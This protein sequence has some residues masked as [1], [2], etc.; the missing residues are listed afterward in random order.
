MNNK[1]A[2]QDRF[3][4]LLDKT[5]E[6]AIIK[7]ILTSPLGLANDLVVCLFE[8]RFKEIKDNLDSI[9]KFVAGIN[10]A[11]QL[12]N[13]YEVA[14][15]YC[16][17]FSFHQFFHSSYRARQGKTLE[18]FFKEIIRKMNASFVV[19]DKKDEK[20]ELMN[21][22]FNKYNSELDID[23]IAKKSNNRI[24]AIQLRSRDDTGGTTAKSSLVE[25]LRDALNLEV[26]KDA[27]LLYLVCVWD[28][29]KGNQKNATIKK[30]YSSLRPHLKIDESSF[31]KKIETGL[32]VKKG[33]VLKMSYGTDIIAKSITDW[34]GSNGTL[35]LESVHKLIKKLENWDDLWL[36]Y[37][38]CSLEL[39]NQA[40]KKVDNIYYLN[41]LI[42]DI[43]YDLKKLSKSNEFVMLANKIALKIIPK[44]KKN[45]IIDGSISDRAHYIRDLI[46]LKFIY[47]LS[48]T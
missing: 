46:L 11:E 3:L 20:K 14:R 34:A 31:A 27:E 8:N 22:I 7:K 10:R 33:V 39:E 24:L 44:W 30:I 23:V 4:L 13:N 19:P 37:S 17:L 42:K 41:S 21:E 16:F 18:E 43:R 26:K 36:A 1:S 25:A 2:Y 47:E 32:T 5:G 28:A 45:S 48:K 15:Y 29:I 35:G 40:V 12:G 6:S 38:V 9:K